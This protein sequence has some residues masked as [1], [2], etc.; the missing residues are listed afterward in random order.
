MQVAIIENSDCPDIAEF[1][2]DDTGKRLLFNS[3]DDAED[4]LMRNAEPGIAYA[5]WGDD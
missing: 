3:Y 4:Y 2:E 1:L 5:K